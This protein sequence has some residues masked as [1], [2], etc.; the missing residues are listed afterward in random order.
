MFKFDIVLNIDEIKLGVVID[1]SVGWKNINGM[2]VKLL[3]DGGE[4]VF[5]LNI[6]SNN[7]C[8]YVTSCT[9]VDDGA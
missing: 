6:D 1:S 3:D 2:F 7:I 5:R 8:D 4:E 9:I